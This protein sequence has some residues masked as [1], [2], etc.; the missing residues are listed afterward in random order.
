MNSILNPDERD[1]KRTAA[2]SIQHPSGASDTNHIDASQYEAL[3]G[4]LR[5]SVKVI[6]DKIADIRSKPGGLSI[7]LDR[8]KQLEEDRDRIIE[9]LCTFDI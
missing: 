5:Y 6:D 9:V 3:L 4:S 8:I 2:V 1:T 7:Y